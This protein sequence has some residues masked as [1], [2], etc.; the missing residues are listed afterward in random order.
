MADLPHL[1]NYVLAPYIKSIDEN[2]LEATVHLPS[3]VEARLR[4]ENFN[5]KIESNES[6][7][8]EVIY[9]IP[10]HSNNEG[11]EVSIKDLVKK[12]FDNQAWRDEVEDAM[13]ESGLI[14]NKTEWVD[15]RV[16]GPS[17]RNSHDDDF[18]VRIDNLPD[19]CG[20]DSL[21]AVL[22][23]R[24]C[25]YF[26]RVVVPSDEQFKFKRFG[27]IK[28]KRLR[29]AIKF[30]EDYSKIMIDGMVLNVALVV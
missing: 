24:G 26:S 22:F 10:T 27:F 15:D 23:D 19:K 5:R 20:P 17:Y 8:R 1:S 21:K 12:D 14:Q 3:A 11:E 9:L 16:I 6:S 30:L 25:N 28:F 7:K 4:N 2:T 18:T 13:K 29:Y